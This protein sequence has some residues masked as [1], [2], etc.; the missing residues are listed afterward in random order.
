MNILDSSI[1]LIDAL[2]GWGLREAHNPKKYGIDLPSDENQRTMLGME[3]V[4]RHVPELIAR[5]LLAE[6]LGVAE[7]RGVL[8]VDFGPDELDKMDLCNGTP[9]ATYTE[10]VSKDETPDHGEYVRRL[11]QDPDVLP[12]VCTVQVAEDDTERLVGPIVVYDGF[13]RAAAWLIRARKGLP[14]RP[15]ADL[16]KTKH[17]PVRP[18]LA[19][20][21]PG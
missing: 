16:I 3:I 5:I 9:L 4:L 13:H 12:L 18:A 15:T 11:V 17:P 10:W 1:R 20:F 14:G 8:R 7:Q 6:P 21:R 19:Y 2:A